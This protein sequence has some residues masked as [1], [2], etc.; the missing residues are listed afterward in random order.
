M[1]EFA[2]PSKIAKPTAPAPLETATP[3]AEDFGPAP[4]PKLKGNG[5]FDRIGDFIG[6]DDGRAALLRSGAETLRSGNI[7]SGI[8]AGAGW[9]DE[10]RMQ[11]AKQAQWD[12]EH[13]LKAQGVDIDQQRADQSGM[14]QAAQ[15]DD[16]AL[17]REIDTAKLEEAIRKA[18]TGEQLDTMEMMLLDKYRSEQTG[19]G[20]ARI[21]QDD[22]NNQRSTGASIYGTDS[23]NMR[24]GSVSADQ[25]YS[26]DGTNWR[27]NNPAQPK[28]FTTWTTKDAETGTTSSGQYPRPSSASINHGRANPALRSQFEQQYG[29]GSWAQF[30]GE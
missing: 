9:M 1:G 23:A 10:Q 12:Q 6:S 17:G 2:P 26:V 22:V 4:A 18:K 3:T 28:P 20:Y 16:M 29:P 15:I 24:H 8:A 5:V 14:Y 25:R 7:G 27:H 11:R 30:I 21:Q 19:L 13:Q